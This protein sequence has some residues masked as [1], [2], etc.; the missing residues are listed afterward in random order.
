VPDLTSVTVFIPPYMPTPEDVAIA[1]DMPRLRLVQAL[2]AGIDGML[3]HLPDVEVRRAVGVHDTST[4]ELAVG[5]MIASL[6]G[7]DVAARDMPHGVWRHERRPALA[8]STVGIVGW[9]GV[10]QAIARRLEPFEVEVVGFSRTGR[11]CLP[12][13]DFD[14]WLPR[15]DVVV[16]ALPGT[17]RPF[18]DASRLAAMRD[19]ALLVNVGRGGLVDTEALLAEL[20]RIAA[21][22]DV[23]DPEPLPAE[24][25]L[26]R[27]PNVL[28][29]PHVGGDTE[30]F[31][32]RARAM[33]AAF[34]RGL[35]A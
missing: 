34:L 20:P 13:A 15:L 2:M 10:G 24:H 5:L 6:R 3:P 32:P 28:V 23:T 14:Q 27:A 17:D 18:L 33:V 35:T 7:L 25:P 31:T 11:G 21:A 22:L 30:A 1:G 12:V 29:T 16:L 19:G 9:G 4:A 8:D 26:W